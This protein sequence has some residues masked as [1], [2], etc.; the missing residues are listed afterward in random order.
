VQRLVE[1]HGAVSTGF[2]VANGRNCSNAQDNTQVSPR[3]IRQAQT[4][5]PKSVQGEGENL[6]ASRSLGQTILEELDNRDRAYYYWSIL[7]FILSFLPMLIAYPPWQLSGQYFPADYGNSAVHIQSLQVL[8]GSD[9]YV[10]MVYCIIVRVLVGGIGK[11]YFALVRFRDNLL[12]VTE[13][14]KNI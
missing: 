11:A 2:T 10:E 4:Q 3:P 9:Q 5:E 8:N 12:S 7:A 1:E 13:H 6:E 14:E